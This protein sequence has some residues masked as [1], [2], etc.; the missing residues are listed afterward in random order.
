MKIIL[1]SDR[2]Y[3]KEHIYPITFKEE[4]Y[5]LTGKKTLS[6]GDIGALKA[7]GFTFEYEHKIV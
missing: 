5:Q 6:H 3:G 2:H 4:L 7:M 1:V